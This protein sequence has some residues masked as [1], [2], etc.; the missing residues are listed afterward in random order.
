MATEA[1][2][3]FAFDRFA[4]DGCPN[5][6]QE[7]HLNSAPCKAES[8]RPATAAAASLVAATGSASREKGVAMTFD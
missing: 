1:S 5:F 3:A 8:A 6:P 7:H 4:D 2:D